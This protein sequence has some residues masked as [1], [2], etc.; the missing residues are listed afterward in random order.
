MI[1]DLLLFIFNDLLFDFVF[2]F[3][4]SDIIA[5]IFTLL[6]AIIVFV[7]TGKRKRDEVKNHYYETSEFI[8]SNFDNAQVV[9]SVLDII[10]GVISI[11]SSYFL[12]SFAFKAVKIFYIP[13]KIVVVANKERSLLKP[14]TKFSFF[15][16]SMRLLEKKGGI[17]AKFIKSNKQTLSF[18]LLVSAFSAV[19][20]YFALPLFVS[21]ANWLYLVIAAGC[22]I[23]VFA[24]IFLVGHDTVESLALRLAKKVLPAE[25][26]EEILKIYNDAVAEL[27]ANKEKE[28]LVAKAKVEAE[29][30]LKAE[31]KEE[32]AKAKE[33]EKDKEVD[34]KKE[35]FEQLVKAQLEDLKKNQ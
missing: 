20:T 15:W 8:R 21:L 12:L 33:Q 10:C 34:A 27:K 29:K 25:K 7:F 3:G 16:T 17:M 2:S 22:F 5:F 18:G 4:S 24:L 14:I 11:F 9:F 19:A 30:R 1:F 23:V 28:A 32:E 13:T 26:Y 35:Q 6:S 31:K